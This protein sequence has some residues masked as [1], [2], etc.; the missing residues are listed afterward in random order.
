MVLGFWGLGLDINVLAEDG[1]LPQDLPFTVH[2]N[3]LWTNK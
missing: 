2:L 3:F 1:G